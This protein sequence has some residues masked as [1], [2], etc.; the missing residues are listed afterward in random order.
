LICEGELYELRGFNLDQ[1]CIVDKLA[2]RSQISFLITNKIY[3]LRLNFILLEDGNSTQ[4]SL[5]IQFESEIHIT[6]V[7]KI[8]EW[9]ILKAYNN[10]L[11]RVEKVSTMKI[12]E[13]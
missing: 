11:I 12:D 2:S 1:L 3:S 10:I 7:Q 8:L 4:I 9:H 5:T 6:F 13:Y